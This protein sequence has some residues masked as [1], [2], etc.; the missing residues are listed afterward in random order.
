[1][2]IVPAPPLVNV[3]VYD[4]GIELDVKL[5]VALLPPLIV[6]LLA[7]KDTLVVLLMVP[8]TT[9]FP[10]PP[11]DVEPLLD[12]EE[13]EP[14]LDVEPLLHV[15]LLEETVTNIGSNILILSSSSTSL[16]PPVSP[17]LLLPMVDLTS[18][19]PGPIALTKPRL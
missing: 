19:V 15:E 13:V 6:I 7:V 16:L 2:V 14:V 5:Q 4:F 17:V 3:Q 10:E 1:M 9:I 11:L 12:V 18:C 8:L